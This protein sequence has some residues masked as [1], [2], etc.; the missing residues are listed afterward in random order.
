M[1]NAM[2][3]RM[4]ETHCFC[5]KTSIVTVN[6]PQTNAGIVGSRDEGG[7]IRRIPQ[8][9]HNSMV[10]IVAAMNHIRLVIHLINRVHI[11][12]QVVRMFRIQGTT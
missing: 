12:N 2:E 7:A 5:K 8:T 3:H 9:Q 11:T 1:Q 10:T 4:E 6:S